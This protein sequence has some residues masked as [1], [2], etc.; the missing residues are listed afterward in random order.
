MAVHLDRSGAVA[1]AEHAS[2]H[3]GSQ[4]AHLPAFAV[5]IEAPGL[6]VQRFDLFGDDE[7]LL[8]NGLISDAGLD[9]G[10]GQSLVPEQ[11]GYGVQAHAS[12]DRLGPGCDVAGGQ[13]HVRSR[14]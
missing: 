5:G 9:H 12:V 7:E 11:G 8:G 3:L 6:V 10:H 1:V 4:L 14:R 2:V 13:S